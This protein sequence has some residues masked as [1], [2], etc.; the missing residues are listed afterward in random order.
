MLSA[1]KYQRAA[2]ISKEE[3]K[4][5]GDYATSITCKSITLCEH[6][7]THSGLQQTITSKEIQGVVMIDLVH[8][9]CV[10]K[11]KTI[12]QLLYIQFFP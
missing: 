4:P 5:D 3:H 8:C 9:K 2:H 11:L 12:V 1:C 7:H 10:S 6:T